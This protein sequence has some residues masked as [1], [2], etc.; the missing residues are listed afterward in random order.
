MEKKIKRI[1]YFT[2]TTRHIK[3]LCHHLC[4]IPD[5][6]FNSI[7][8]PL[9]SRCS[10]SSQQKY[11]F[12]STDT[13]PPFLVNLLK[14]LI[15]NKI[16]TNIKKRVRKIYS[17]CARN[18]CVSLLILL[19]VSLGKPASI[20]LSMISPLIC[21]PRGTDRRKRGLRHTTKKNSPRPFS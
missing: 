12:L 8:S 18:I 2:G 20:N 13:N 11:F 21:R 19:A 7:H 9:F 1:C 17:Q 10:Q 16:S 15:S 14:C 3:L 5:L 6:S 4:H